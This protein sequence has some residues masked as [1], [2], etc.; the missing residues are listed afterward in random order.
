MPENAGILGRYHRRKFDLT[1][2]RTTRTAFR[3][4]YA[5]AKS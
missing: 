4:V 3:K 2:N 5:H 1:A